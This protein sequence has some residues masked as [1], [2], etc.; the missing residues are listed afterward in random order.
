MPKILPGSPKCSLMHRKTGPT[1][2][3]SHHIENTSHDNTMIIMPNTALHAPHLPP[4]PAKRRK[5]RPHRHVPAKLPRDLFAPAQI[6]SYHRPEPRLHP[7]RAGLLSRALPPPSVRSPARPGGKRQERKGRKGRKDR[8]GSAGG[9]IPP[10]PPR[11]ALRLRRAADAVQK[12]KSRSSKRQEKSG[13]TPW[14]QVPADAFRTAIS[15]QACALRPPAV[16]DR[17]PRFRGHIGVVGR[18]FRIFKGE[19]DSRLWEAFVARRQS[20]CNAQAG[21]RW[22]RTAVFQRSSGPS[23]TENSHLSTLGGPGTLSSGP[24]GGHD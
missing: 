23:F 18:D 2:R 13:V 19:F 8:K 14:P 20:L 3:P 16:A 6:Q 17:C 7:C 24:A 21:R 4:I 9:M 15:V 11:F 12:T 10:E 5:T 22:S 1:P